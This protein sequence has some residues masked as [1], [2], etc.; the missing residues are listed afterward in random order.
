M[1]GGGPKMF[2]KKLPIVKKIFNFC[3]LYSSGKMSGKH[4]QDET[5]AQYNSKALQG[6]PV[7]FVSAMRTLFDV[8]DDKKSG[9]ISLT[10]IETRWTQK[11][12]EGGAVPSGVI[13]CLRYKG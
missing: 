9:F 3:I 5:S 7:K 13:D 1:G 12:E 11:E 4:F 6:L 10:D 2:S 8:L